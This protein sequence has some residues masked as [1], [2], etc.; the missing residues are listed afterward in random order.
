M[1]RGF[2][3]HDHRLVNDL[4]GVWDFIFLGDRDPESLEIQNI[5]YDDRLAVPGCFDASPRYAGFR[6]LAAYRRWINIQ[7]DSPYRLIFHGLN[8]WC[9]VFLG[10]NF[11]GEH[12]GGY[13]RFHFD[14]WDHQP[15]IQELL[16]LA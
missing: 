9:K 14:I 12:Q 3:E 10:G 5:Y 13:T 1:A 15:G 4:N 7:D 16:I 11:V 2:T 8:Q 6:G